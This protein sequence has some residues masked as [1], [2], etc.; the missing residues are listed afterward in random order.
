MTA[1]EKTAELHRLLSLAVYE[2]SN[3]KILALQDGPPREDAA[4]SCVHFHLSAAQ[5]LYLTWLE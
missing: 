3:G 4:A 2:V 5:H 1:G